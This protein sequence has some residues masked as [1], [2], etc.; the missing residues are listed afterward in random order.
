MKAPYNIDSSFRLPNS[1]FQNPSLSKSDN[2]L[3]KGW[4]F[5]LLSLFSFGIN[6]QW[7]TTGNNNISNTSVLGSN[8][9]N[10]FALKVITNGQQRMYIHGT[11]DDR[12]TIGIGT[13]TPNYTMQLHSTAATPYYIA[14]PHGT[15]DP[16]PDNGT[17]SMVQFTN[18]ES[19]TA[20][21]DGLRLGVRGDKC[22]FLCEDKLQM[23]VRNSDSKINL[24][25]WG[26]IDFFG[27][28]NATSSAR[29]R[30]AADNQNGFM[31]RKTQGEG[32]FG[33]QV[34]TS[35]IDINAIEVERYGDVAFVVKNDG[36]V[37]IGNMAPEENFKLD[38]SGRINGEELSLSNS[39][40]FSSGQTGLGTQSPDETCMLDVAGKTRATELLL[41]NSVFLPSGQVGLGTLEPDANCMLDVSGKTK[42]TEL[43]LTNSVFFPSGQVGLGTL[44]PDAAYFLDVAGKIRGCEVR[45]NN[46]GWCDYVFADNYHL[47]SLAELEAYITQHHH[48]PEMLSEK[49]VN[50]QGGF[51][52]AKM[53]TSLL[54][55]SEENTLYIL[56]L[57]K[58]LSEEQV[59][60]NE[61]EKRLLE[62]ELKME[63][64]LLAM[65]EK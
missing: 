26:Q 51:D 22:Y 60:N 37:G 28:G 17:E 59:K 52:L 34:Q 39:I 15:I 2:A 19:G 30:L 14:P 7:E 3:F 4:M 20:Y 61:L 32:T 23:I 45:V 12:A 21:N 55:R 11:D 62:L 40:M 41:T 38:V 64:L 36:R 13:N 49:E 8:L 53:S 35:H 5:L 57:Q 65:S 43:L 44:A 24:N 47:M 46:P 27:S 1:S 18:Q 29:L 9:N 25:A 16:N 56:N 50:E 48:L 42:A 63:K 54:K 31:I 6:A 10:N 58:E 33:L